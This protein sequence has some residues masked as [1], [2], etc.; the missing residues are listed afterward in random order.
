MS[1]IL[2][3]CLMAWLGHPWIWTR[4]PSNENNAT[5]LHTEGTMKTNSEQSRPLHKSNIRKNF[6]RKR[7]NTTSQRAII[8][9]QGHFFPEA[10]SFNGHWICWGDG[11]K[12]M[13]QGSVNFYWFFQSRW[14]VMH[15]D[16]SRHRGHTEACVDW[17][18]ESQSRNQICVIKPVTHITW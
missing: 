3:Q 1:S 10:I 18:G 4:S 15:Y 9:G 14:S 7:E 12:D 16:G 11:W 17:T 5:L 13:K 6:R 8:V 2:Q